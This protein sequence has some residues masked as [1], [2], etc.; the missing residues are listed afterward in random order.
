[1]G[2]DLDDLGG[3][4]SSS[5]W[6]G[7]EN[8]MLDDDGNPWPRGQLISFD[9]EDMGGHIPSNVDRIHTTPQLAAPAGLM[10][11]ASAQVHEKFLSTNS[12]AYDHVVAAD[13]V[14]LRRQAQKAANEQNDLD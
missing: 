2:I 14:K 11:E 10:S 3:E 9:D 8:E 6:S 7:S 5:D 4:Q 1:M 13:E 12:P